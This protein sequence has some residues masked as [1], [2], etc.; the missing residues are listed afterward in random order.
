MI[1][2]DKFTLSMVVGELLHDASAAIPAIWLTQ[3]DILEAARLAFPDSTFVSL[4]ESSKLLKIPE[5]K[6]LEA[7]DW[8]LP[9]DDSKDLYII[10]PSEIFSKLQNSQIP[11]PTFLERISSYSIASRAVRKEV[12]NLLKV[13]NPAAHSTCVV[14]WSY[15]ITDVG[16]GQSTV[17]TCTP[18]AS[19]F[20]YGMLNEDLKIDNCFYARVAQEHFQPERPE[21]SFPTKLLVSGRYW[22]VLNYGEGELSVRLHDCDTH[23]HMLISDNELGDTIIPEGELSESK[24]LSSIDYD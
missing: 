23:G 14:N 8:T 16:D 10:W 18:I 11:N 24:I 13:Y 21:I 3:E 5:Y 15:V 17:A 19:V 9:P 6:I 7:L 12:L 4:Q 1:S 22:E 2:S 20:D